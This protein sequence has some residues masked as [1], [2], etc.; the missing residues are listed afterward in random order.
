MKVRIGIAAA[1]GA[2]ALL[3]AGCGGDDGGNKV[4]SVSSGAKPDGQA[5]EAKTDGGGT[6]EDKMRAFAKCMREHGVDMPDPEPGE[7]G[8]VRMKALGAD[9]DK[10]KMDEAHNACKTLL[11]NGGEPRK[12]EGKELDEARARAKCMRDH[13]VDMPDPDPN[14]AGRTI[15]IPEGADKSKMDA[16]MKECGMGVS[17]SRK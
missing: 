16:A 4:A 6:D 13:G 8:G 15:K 3:T 7:N 14:G 5:N 1:A 11:P 9:V 17:A 12:L 2:L 10:A